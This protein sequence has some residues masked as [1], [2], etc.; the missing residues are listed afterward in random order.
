MCKEIQIQFKNKQFCHQIIVFFSFFIEKINNQ[1]I[2][3]TLK[4]EKYIH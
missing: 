2:S 4:F 1:A 3:H